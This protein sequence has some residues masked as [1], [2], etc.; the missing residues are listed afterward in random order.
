ML[1]PLVAVDHTLSRGPEG[2]LVTCKLLM[3][4]QMS[5]EVVVGSGSVGAVGAREGFL[6][7]V[8]VHVSLKVSDKLAGVGAVWALT[9]LPV[10]LTPG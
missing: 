4:A 2:T 10:A 9:D 7:R 1:H 3:S 5:F 8:S 6:A